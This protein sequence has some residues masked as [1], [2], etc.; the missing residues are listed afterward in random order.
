ME[1]HEN[2]LSERRDLNPERIEN[3]HSLTV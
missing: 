2:S 1:V 3:G